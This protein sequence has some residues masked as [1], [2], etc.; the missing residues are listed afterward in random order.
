MAWRILNLFRKPIP[1]GEIISDKYI[2]FGEK[3]AFP[4]IWRELIDNSPSG[5]SCLSTL[6][7][8][9][10]GYGF[11]DADLEK[12]IV[13]SRGQTLWQLHQEAVDSLGTFDGFYQLVRFNGAGQVTDWTNL[14]FENCRLGKPDSTGYISTIIYNPFFG[15]QYYNQNENVVYNVW[16]PET[17]QDE[18]RVQ[19]DGYKGQIFFFGTTTPLSR[20]YPKPEAFSAYRWMEIEAGVAKY[21]T[22]NINR[23]FMPK[24]MLTLFGNPNEPSTN[25]D[26]Q[27][28][29]GGQPATVA[30][31]FDDQ[32]NK[33]F[34]GIENLNNM[35]INWSNNKDEKPSIDPFPTAANGDMFLTLDN[36]A[37]KKITIAWKVPSILANINEGVSLGGD[38]N[39]VRV[40]VKLMQ[41]RVVNPQR[42]LT[43]AYQMILKRSA[44]PYAQD[45]YITPYNPYPELEIID[46]KLWNALTPEEQRRWI[47]KNTEI[48]LDT[49]GQT[50][51]QNVV[52]LKY[53]EKIVKSIKRVND[54]ILMTGQKCSGKWG[55]EIADR[56]VNN[57]NMGQKEMKRLKNY[58]KSNERFSNTVFSDSCDSLKYHQLGGKEM[59]DFL[60]AE[61]TRV[62][63]WLN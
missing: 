27:D 24:F 29:N 26:Y 44:N 36:Q 14:F 23:G 57:K 10:E 58:L 9:I 49:P 12:R 3:D 53:P 15:T 56:I 11:S 31:E 40:A 62:E 37:T 2:P 42:Y 41:Q 30:Q 32:I 48:S 39:M 17:V 35:W 55:E 18:I 19:G 20:Y 1:R 4:L 63:Q 60:E 59:H 52:S 46:D 43:D 5:T 7:D 34:M 13:N 16:N 51:I 6:K 21:H 50:T 8:F 61:L 54:Y 45:I 33:D 38:G 47:Q 22:G 25:P 28:F